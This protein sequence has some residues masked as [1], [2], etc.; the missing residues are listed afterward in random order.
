MPWS[1]GQSPAGC[2]YAPSTAPRAV[3][4]T[5]WPGWSRSAPTWP[6]RPGR[7]R[8]SPAPPWSCMRRSRSTPG[9][10]RSSR[11]SP[12]ASRTPPPRPEPRCC[13]R[14]TCTCT[15]ASP[16][17]CHG[18]DRAE[19]RHRPQGPDPGRD[20]RRPAGP[21]RRGDLRVTIGRPSDYYAPHARRLRPGRPCSAPRCV[22]GPLTRSARSTPRTRC[23]TSRRRRGP[24][25]PRRARDR[26]RTRVAPVVAESLTMRQFAD[27]VA[28]EI[29][30][31]GSVGASCVVMLRL[32]GPAMPMMR[33]LAGVAYQWKRPFV[34]DDSAFRASFPDAV[35]GHLASGRRRRHHP[36]VARPSQDDRPATCMEPTKP[37]M[38]STHRGVGGTGRAG[39]LSST[40][41]GTDD[42]ASGAPRWMH[43][44]GVDRPAEVPDCLPGDPGPPERPHPLPR[45]PR[46]PTHPQTPTQ[47]G[48]CDSPLNPP[49][50]SHHQC[51]T[52]PAPSGNGRGARMNLEPVGAR[53]SAQPADLLIRGRRCGGMID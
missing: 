50:P 1:P 24:A 26:R 41:G 21:L 12:P 2:G 8:P 18:R 23:R 36:L 34:V 28:A 45:Q 30:P 42:R 15:A 14:T 11:R 25:H 22:A 4:P 43:L 5:R 20:G 46:W 47:S 27:L 6:P 29:D 38:T 31:A 33:E 44:F 32:L 17:A 7:P 35:H 19:R 39:V 9:G 37:G 10:A 53:N 48:H 13:S 3:P 52:Q 40:G 51:P 49:R 16:E